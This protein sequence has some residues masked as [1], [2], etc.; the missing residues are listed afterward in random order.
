MIKAE[1]ARKKIIEDISK[2][3][4]IKNINDTIYAAIAAHKFNCIIEIDE[5]DEG[6]EVDM[7]TTGI[8]AIRYLE[9]LGY[10]ACIKTLNLKYV[11]IS[12]SWA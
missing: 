10:T 11:E 6:I 9:S 1:D 7:Q 2:S 4:Y 12:V 5:Y 3:G 8:C